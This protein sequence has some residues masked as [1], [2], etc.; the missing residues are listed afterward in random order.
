MKEIDLF[1]FE[2]GSE[3]DKRYTAKIQIPHY[4]PK[5]DM[6]SIYSLVDDRKYKELISNIEKSNLPDAEKEFLRMGAT[7]HLAFNYSRI[8]DYYANASKEMQELMEQSALVII[9]INDAIA[10]GYASMSKNIEKIVRQFSD[11]SESKTGKYTEEDFR[12]GNPF[13]K[14]AT[15]FNEE[16]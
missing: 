4:E 15:A 12:N 11:V 10:N 16:V 8:A 6:P 7:R 5:N 13:D 9:D 2:E 14:G 3:N 1:G